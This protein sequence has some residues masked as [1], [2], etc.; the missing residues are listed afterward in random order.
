MQLL[1][2]KLLRLGC[3]EEEEEKKEE[4]E[5]EEEEE[6]EAEEKEEEEGGRLS[7][8][9]EAANQKPFF[10][11]TEVRGSYTQHLYIFMNTN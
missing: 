5:A 10:T 6:E 1:V 7:L 11:T 3:A 2:N 8:P 4:E 9:Q